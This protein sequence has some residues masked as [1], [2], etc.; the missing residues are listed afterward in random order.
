MDMQM[1][2]A[3]IAFRDEVRTFFRD[4]LPK[5]IRDK[6]VMGQR[7][8]AEDLARWHRILDDKGWAAPQWTPEWGGTTWSPVQHYIFK[9]ELQMAPAPDPP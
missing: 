8:S 5:D 6:M 1:T 3:D 4:A 2:R 7:Y 9:E